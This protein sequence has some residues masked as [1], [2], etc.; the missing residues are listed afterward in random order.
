MISTRA[1]G[2]EA[3][4]E[5]DHAGERE[6]GWEPWAAGSVIPSSTGA[7]AVRASR[8]T[9]GADAKPKMRSAMTA[10]ITTPAGEHGL[11]DRERRQRERRHVQDPGAGRDEHAD[12]EPRERNRSRAVRSGWWTSTAGAATAHGAC[13]GTRVRGEAQANASR[14]PM[15][16]SSCGLQACAGC[17]ANGDAPHSLRLR[18]ALP[19]H[20]TPAMQGRVPIRTFARRRASCGSGARPLRPDVVEQKPILLVDVDGV[21]SLFGFAPGARPEG[22]FEMVDGIAHFLSA[23]AGDHLRRLAAAFEPVWCTGWEE[24]A[25]EYL[26]HALGLDGP[27]PFLSFDRDV[28][29]RA[30]TGTGSS[31]RSTRMRGRGRSRGST[32]RTG[33]RARPGRRRAARRRCW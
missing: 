23:T 16:R 28:R 4:L 24:K 19:L 11:H 6:G 27:W 20:S 15:F 17:G 21:I 29:R 2:D 10:S 26:P 22:R 14:M 13:R 32:T 8:P 5:G 30:C 9:G 1:D 33:R 3:R 12:R 25:N 18:D 7:D 31:R